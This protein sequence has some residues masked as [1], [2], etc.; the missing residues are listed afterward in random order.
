MYVLEIAEYQTLNELQNVDL[1]GHIATFYG[2][3]IANVAQDVGIVFCFGFLLRVVACALMHFLDR[4]K[5]A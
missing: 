2:Y 3:Y 5:K 4:A 1:D